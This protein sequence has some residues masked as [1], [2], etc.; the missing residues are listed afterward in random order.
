MDKKILTIL[1]L[2]LTLTF[3]VI[4]NTS[5]SETLIFAISADVNQLDPGDTN[6]SQAVSNIFESLVKFKEELQV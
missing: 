5:A 3:G 4:G 1:L 6:I 2:I